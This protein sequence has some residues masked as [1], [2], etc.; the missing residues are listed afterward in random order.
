[1]G[2]SEKIVHTRKYREKIDCTYRRRVANAYQTRYWSLMN[3]FVP[4]TFRLGE[5]F[6]VDKIYKK[7]ND[8]C[9]AFR[10][11]YIYFWVRKIFL[12]GFVKDDII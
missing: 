12:H 5:K 3:F 4:A 7:K 1:M 6:F 11:I 8:S 10:N 9:I 2:T